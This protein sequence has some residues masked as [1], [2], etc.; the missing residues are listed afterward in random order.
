MFDVVAFGELLID[1]ISDGVGTNGNPVYEANPGGA[2]CNVLAM[3][4][5]LGYHTAFIG[6]V[7]KDD[8]GR[9][10]IAALQSIGISTEGLIADEKANTTLAFVHKKPDGDRDFSFYREKGADT[11]LQKEEIDLSL[12]ENCRIFHFGTLSM[13]DEPALSAT[14]FALE[15]AKRAG[16]LVSFDPNYRPPLWKNEALAKKAALYGIKNCDIL[17]IADNELQWLTGIEDIDSAVEQ[18]KQ[19]SSAKLMFVTLG[20]KGSLAYTQNR[21]VYAPAF[22][23]PKTVDTTGAGDTFC[24]CALGFTLQHGIYDLTEKQLSD[25]LR[26]ANAAA[27]IVTTRKGALLSMPEQ[28][29]IEALF[30]EKEA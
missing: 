28:K 10:L 3:L 4:G 22:L 6:K 2:P 29:E 25:L 20:K 18:L 7:G 26:F 8:F 5:K 13:T 9:Q 17:K 11:L 1:F 16:A 19:Q 30:H 27:S 14:K 23:T 21:K 15:H 24:A 12:L